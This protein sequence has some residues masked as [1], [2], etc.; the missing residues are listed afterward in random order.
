MPEDRRESAEDLLKLLRAV[1]DTHRSADVYDPVV[2]G[3]TALRAALKRLDVPVPELDP[4]PVL[5][6]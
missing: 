2:A 5:P 3:D 1:T 6:L 4:D